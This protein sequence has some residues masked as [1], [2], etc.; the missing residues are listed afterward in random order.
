M[1]RSVAFSLV[2]L[3]IVGLGLCCGR[4]VGPTVRA[5]MRNAAWGT[6]EGIAHAEGQ[7]A[8]Y[9]QTL[10]C[11]QIK[12][13]LASVVG[14]QTINSRGLWCLTGDLIWDSGHTGPPITFSSGADGATFDLNG[15]S[16]T[17]PGGCFE[18][19][20]T[21]AIQ[22][23]GGAHILIENGGIQ[24]FS[25]GIWN[26]TSGGGATYVKIKD[27]LISGGS[28]G[29]YGIILT[30]NAAHIDVDH[31]TLTDFGISGGGEGIYSDGSGGFISIHDCTF[32]LPA[33][34][35]DI[36]IDDNSNIG[37]NSGHDL[38]RDNKFLGGGY[39]IYSF[40]TTLKYINNVQWTTW[41]YAGGSN[42]SNF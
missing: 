14:Q 9:T 12:G 37:S 35:D 7:S 25:T 31:V 33:A 5:G 18:A 19:Y 8:S 6:G 28:G 4:V 39:A 34:S 23:N 38:I 2:A 42:I 16:I 27:M 3:G 11:T 41:Q 32:N 40:V 30:D 24:G 15:Y 1:K 10:A 20:A 17:C 21:T 13:G 36:L 29:F 22:M 26:G